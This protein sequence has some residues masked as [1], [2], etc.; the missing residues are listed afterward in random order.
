MH[1]ILMT[2]FH[3]L[4]SR[5]HILMFVLFLLRTLFSLTGLFVLLFM[6]ILVLWCSGYHVCFTRRRSRVRTSPEPFIIVDTLITR[7][8]YLKI[9][10]TIL[11]LRLFCIGLTPQWI[12]SA[13]VS[14]ECSSIIL[15]HNF[16]FLCGCTFWA[17]LRDLLLISQYRAV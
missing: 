7:I 9:M 6:N 3:S 4:S 17:E 13:F 5:I 10:W 12:A 1:C 15:I 16:F 11:K 2:V 8:V 14:H